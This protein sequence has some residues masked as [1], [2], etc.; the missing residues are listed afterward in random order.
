MGKET[1]VCDAQWPE[2]DEKYLVEQTVTYAVSFNGK[3]RFS[4]QVAN[5]TSKE[6]VERLALENPASEK[7]I[8]G[9]TPRKIIVVP[10]KIVNIVI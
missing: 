6:E 8:E 5:G 3:A 2:F 10:N 1:T 4:M 9:K 7:W